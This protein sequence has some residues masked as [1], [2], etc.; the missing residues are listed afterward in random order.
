MM[1]NKR[2]RASRESI[3]VLLEIGRNYNDIYW[4]RV[5]FINFFIESQEACKR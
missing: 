5:I 2:A 3:E 4:S 1:S